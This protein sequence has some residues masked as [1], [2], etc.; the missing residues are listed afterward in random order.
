MRTFIFL[1]LLLNSVFTQAELEAGIGIGY[2]HVPDY[3]GSDEAEDYLL[4]VPYLRYRSEKLSID[5][6]AIQGNL[7]QSGHW[8]LE[9]SFG[10]AIRVESDN[11][12]A[13]E[14]M[15][16]VDF[17]GEAGPALHYYFRGDR[18]NDNALFLVLPLR[19]A[20][21]TDFT[22]AAFRGAT[23]NPVLNWRH[24]YRSKQLEVRS[25]LSTEVRS[26]TAAYHDYFYGVE[27][28]FATTERAQYSAGSGFGGYGVSYSLALIRDHYLAAGFLR[29]VDVSAADFADSPL[30]RQNTNLVF[31]VALV[32]LF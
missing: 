27:Q 13:R 14:G 24:S 17:L 28:K 12:K 30:V 5:R 29:Y 10:G 8:S 4:P 1:S 6:N 32:Y 7:W 3:F 11:N 31:G 2:A 16:D 19:S 15:D 18:N 25:Q 23:F 9:L 26:A 20:I 22:S 21:S